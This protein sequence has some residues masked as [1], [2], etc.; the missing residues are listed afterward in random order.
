MGSIVFGALSPS[1]AADSVMRITYSQ[2]WVWDLYVSHGAWFVRCVYGS[3]LLLVGGWL[4]QWVFVLQD[5]LAHRKLLVRRLNARRMRA[6]YTLSP[7]T[8]TPRVP[9]VSGGWRLIVVQ[10]PFYSGFDESTMVFLQS[11]RP[12]GL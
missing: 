7:F 2:V 12:L 5:D 1:W 9:S 8:S 10:T 6:G 4:C 3:F 11:Y